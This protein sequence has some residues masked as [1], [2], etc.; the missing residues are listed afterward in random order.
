MP[1][2]PDF[3]EIA[4]RILLTVD[5]VVSS[6]GSTPGSVTNAIAEDL[7]LVWNARGVADIGAIE[8]AYDADSP[9]MK[10]LDRAIKALDR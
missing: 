9:S 6:P 1:Q 4:L 3:D 2:I 8:T 10:K 7:R 5:H